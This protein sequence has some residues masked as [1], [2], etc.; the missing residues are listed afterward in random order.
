[1]NI[2]IFYNKDVLL[3]AKDANSVFNV[4]K[5][6]IGKPTVIQ[7]Q[8]KGRQ[9]QELCL[10]Q[11]RRLTFQKCYLHTGITELSVTSYLGTFC[12]IHFQNKN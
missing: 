3:S 8:Q 4:I 2:S 1:M 12:S 9:G 6:I 11:S 10:A 5:Y 7:K